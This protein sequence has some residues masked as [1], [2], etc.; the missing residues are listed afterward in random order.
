MV[1]LL[2]IPAMACRAVTGLKPTMPAVDASP[3]L[4]A[5]LPAAT[6]L[7]QQLTQTS[8]PL[9]ESDPGNGYPKY[10]ITAQTPQLSGSD[11]PRVTALN[12][13]LRDLVAT[14]VNTWRESYK[15]LPLTSL[16]NGS[17]LDITYDLIWQSGDL[18][19]Y[20]FNVNFYA[21]T[22][23]HAGHESITLTYDLAHGRELSLG[24]LFQPNANYLEVISANCIAQLQTQPFFEG[25][26][27]DGA[28][29][30]PENYRLWNL[31]PDG[32][33]I[34]FAEYQVA[35]GAAGPQTMIVPYSALASVLDPQ[36]PL[37]QSVP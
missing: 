33:L 2:V 36:G 20:K 9:S 23:A 13:R 34:T 1:S 6:T 31:G 37:A 15:Q 5:S 10:T 8:I 27:Q 29:P 19:S 22:A 21:D 32:L 18:W 11:D 26:F 17:S 24:D 4:A 7:S 28:S 12:Q 35:P 14:E 30:S 16:S 25:P 3:T